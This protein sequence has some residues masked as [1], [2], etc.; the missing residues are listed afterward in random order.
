MTIRIPE[1]RQAD[2]I[3]Y[4]KRPN[5]VRRQLRN[6]EEQCEIGTMPS[7]KTGGPGYASP[8][9]EVGLHR[10]LGLSELKLKRELDRS[11]TAY[12]IQ[13]TET[14]TSQVTTFQT[15]PEHLS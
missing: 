2:V 12:L 9:E 13:G 3:R 1:V 5:S 11:R 14:A 15:S 7:K 6:N 10:R 4:R 8:I